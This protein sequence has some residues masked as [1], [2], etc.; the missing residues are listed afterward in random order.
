M[1][2]DRFIPIKYNSLL[3]FSDRVDYDFD[4]EDANDGDD[5]YL[6]YLLASSEMIPLGVFLHEC[7]YEKK[8]SKTLNKT[9][10]RNR[11]EKRK[12]LFKNKMKDSHYSFIGENVREL[13]GEYGTNITASYMLVMVRKD[14][15]EMYH[16]N[17][18][19]F[20]VK[21]IYRIA[22]LNLKKFR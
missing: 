17:E 10:T 13:G 5:E 11:K 19:Y 18:D 2:A 8:K 1:V 12:L 3:G 15:S 6:N 22:L 4:P 9:T 7:S 14:A 21:S 20:E 16:G